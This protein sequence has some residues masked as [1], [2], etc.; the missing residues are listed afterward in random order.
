MP[1]PLAATNGPKPLAPRAG[2]LH[3]SIA[4]ARTTRQNRPGSGT[5]NTESEAVSVN[6]P[7]RFAPGR[8]AGTVL[9]TQ[10]IIRL[11]FPTFFAR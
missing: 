9:A 7:F 11:H 4:P 1:R 5:L 10:F 2:S 3:T 8:P 6:T